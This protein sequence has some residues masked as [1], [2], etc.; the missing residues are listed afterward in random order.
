LPLGEET[1]VQNE[2]APESLDVNSLTHGTEPFLRSRQLC[3]YSRTKTKLRGLSPQENYTDRATA[4][5]RPS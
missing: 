2:Q 5:C 1:P 3:S 4:A